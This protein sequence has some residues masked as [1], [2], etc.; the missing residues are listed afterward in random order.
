MNNEQQG[1][2]DRVI[3]DEEIEDQNKNDYGKKQKIKLFE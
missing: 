3:S 2:A 1:Q